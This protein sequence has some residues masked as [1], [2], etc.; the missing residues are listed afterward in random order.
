MYLQKLNAILLEA[1]YDSMVI[2]MQKSFPTQSTEIANEVKWAKTQL[3]KQDRIVWF[4]KVLKL[5]LAGSLDQKSLGDYQFTSIDQLKTDLLHFY[6]YNVSSIDSY[7]FQNQSVGQ[8]LSDLKKI[9]AE[10]QE[11]QKAKTPKE[12]PVTPMSGDKVIFDFGAGLQWWFVN[13]AYC[14]DEGRS[15]NHCGNVVGQHKTDER[16]LSLRKDGHVLMTFI[17]EP[18]GKLGEMKAHSN[19]KPAQKYHSQ[20]LKLLLWDKITGIAG[21]GYLPS[22]NFSIFDLSESDIKIID[23]Q[24]PILIIDQIKISPADILNAPEF[25]KN[26]YKK[27][28]NPVLRP[29]LG[30]ASVDAW[31]NA[32]EN[33]KSLIIYAPHDMPEFEEKLLKYANIA[34]RNLLLKCPSSIS[35]NHNLVKKM[36]SVNPWLIAGVIPTTP[37]Y[38][39]LCLAAVTHHG[40]ALTYV[41]KELRDKQICL[42]AV[43]NDGQALERVPKEL[44]DK[45]MC[46]IAV[47]NGSQ[48]LEYVPAKL[49]DKQMCLTAVT[50]DGQ[51][52][53]HV[54]AKLRDKQ[55][56]LTAV[57][58]YG[59]AL[60]H[61]PYELRDKQICLAAVTNDGQALEHVPY[62]LRDKQICLTA[63]TNDGPALE[64]VPAELRDKQMCLAAVTDY[65]PAMAFVPG[66]LRDTIKNE[67]NKHTN[68]SIITY[69]ARCIVER[70]E[71]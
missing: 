29:L 44:R 65:G 57:T 51:A 9:L 7:V 32:V 50:N 42:A 56:Y 34:E 33:D 36:I 58:H 28:V 16:I 13:R 24:K 4:L 10:Y 68:E 3:K 47:T 70:I 6:G 27:Y 60:M 69:L 54:P 2:A 63:V 30:G 8:V 61:V 71:F 59:Y 48:A 67:L 22:A 41:P 18:N 40:D 43:T 64:Y 5:Y 25:I 20:I 35:K 49:R 62:E 19:Q 17:L 11:K 12:K 23:Q 31:R 53:I 14:S 38:R 39:D 45:Q 52:L 46:L 15:G 26:K 55:M 21:M 37:G 1:S 66:E